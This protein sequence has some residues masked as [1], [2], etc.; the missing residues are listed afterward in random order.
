MVSEHDNDKY[1]K[2]I[3]LIVHKN[4]YRCEIMTV[5]IRESKFN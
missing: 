1:T 2:Y 3:Q 4:T 5:Y